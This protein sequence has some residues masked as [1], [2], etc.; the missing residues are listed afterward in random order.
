MPTA[1][2]FAGALCLVWV[3]AHYGP[4]GKGESMALSDEDQA[5][6]RPSQTVPAPAADD[7]AWERL[8]NQM[9]WYYRESCVHQR[10]CEGLGCSRATEAP[11]LRRYAAPFA[12]SND[13]MRSSRRLNFWDEKDPLADLS[14]RLDGALPAYNCWGNATHFAGHG[15]A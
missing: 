8:E 12:W 10:R 4:L 13:A 3:T 11:T 15:P 1:D 14:T 7:P 9:G 2:D 6:T 5:P